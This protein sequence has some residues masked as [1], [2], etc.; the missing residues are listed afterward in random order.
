MKL[1]QMR[2]FC[3]LT[4]KAEYIVR[5]SQFAVLIVTREVLDLTSSFLRHFAQLTGMAGGKPSLE[6]K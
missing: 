4:V 3:T 1:I 5:Y 2:S 6:I